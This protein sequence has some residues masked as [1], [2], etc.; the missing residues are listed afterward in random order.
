MYQFKLLLHSYIEGEADLNDLIQEINRLAREDASTAQEAL[1]HCGVLS[2]KGILTTKAHNRLIQ[3][4][5]K[6][7][8]HAPINSLSNID[9]TILVD[10]TITQQGNTST[11]ISDHS[12][13]FITDFQ[14]DLSSKSIPEIGSKLKDRFILVKELGRGGMGVVYKAR[15]FRKEETHD[16]EPFVAIKVLTREFQEKK[17]SV[18]ALQRETKKA[19]ILAHPNIITVFDFDRDGE[20]VFMTMEYLE[21]ETLSTIIKKEPE[22]PLEQKRAL[23]IIEQMG[24]AL[25]YAHKRGI[26]HS[27]FKPGNVFVTNSDVVKVLDFGIARAAILPEQQNTEDSIFDAGDLHALTPVYAS[28]EMLE[29]KVPDPR[30]DIYGL[31]VTA[32]LLLTGKHPFYRFPATK[33]HAEGFKPRH[34]DKLPRSIKIALTHALEFDRDKRTAS[35]NQFLQELNLR[36]RRKKS[37]KRRLFEIAAISVFMLLTFYI[38]SEFFNVEQPQIKLKDTAEITD[39]D[40]QQKVEDLLEIA[41]VHIMVKRLI[42]PPGSSAFY[43]FQQVLE[44]HENNKQATEGL[45]KIA[46][47]YE[48]NARE[49]LD[50]GDLDRALQLVNKGLFAFPSHQGLDNIGN[51]IERLK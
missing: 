42:D 43:A 8:S 27:D 22:K 2:E 37:V 5:E 10:T 48:K 18:I 36:P 31:A 1:L 25:A 39:P 30:D 16:S 20:N 13:T 3:E 44:I 24:R 28:K 46:D 45:R 4:V 32:C 35:A 9:K 34:I 12:K 29:G 49:R 21:G 15:D 38:T 33:A 47:H 26:V 6:L 50:S 41:N 14:Q 7:Q 51:E 40:V 23:S 19:Q 17:I 11:A